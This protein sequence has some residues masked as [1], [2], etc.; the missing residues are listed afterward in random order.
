[1]M[2][3]RAGG[4]ACQPTFGSCPVVEKVINAIILD[5]NRFAAAKHVTGIRT[6]AK[7]QDHTLIFGIKAPTASG[8]VVSIMDGFDGAV[9]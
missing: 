1:M 6:F 5:E 3:I 9:V 4:E 7:G 8:T 2:Q